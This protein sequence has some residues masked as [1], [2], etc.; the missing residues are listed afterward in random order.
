MGKK[1]KHIAE[2]KIRAIKEYLEGN[3][4]MGSIAKQLGINKESFRQGVANYESMGT[5]AFFAEQNKHYSKAEKEQA[6]TSY[7]ASEGSFMDICK[8]YKIHSTA[9]LK[10]WVKK[11]NGHEKLNASGT[12]GIAI[13]TKGR[14][15]SVY[16]GYK[17]DKIEMRGDRAEMSDFPLYLN[18]VAGGLDRRDQTIGGFSFVVKIY[19]L[20]V[21]E[22]I[23]QLLYLL[24]RYGFNTQ[25]GDC[26]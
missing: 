17:Q 14:K 8:K 18:T 11:Y 15:T 4:S 2:E 10:T 3:S 25:F 1:S 22:I 7:L 20:P 9:Q 24:G 13:M 21:V 16:K 5:E 23:G 19:A 12:G 6:I 26:P